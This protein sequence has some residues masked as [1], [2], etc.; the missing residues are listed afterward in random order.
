MSTTQDIQLLDKQELQ[1]RA[2]NV[3]VSHLL[4]KINE[5]IEAMNEKT[6]KQVIKKKVK[7]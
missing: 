7:E 5:I 1:K 3:I 4:D 6:K 2:S